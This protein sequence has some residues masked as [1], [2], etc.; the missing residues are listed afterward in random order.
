MMPMDSQLLD[1][2]ASM[3][4]PSLAPT[5]PQGTPLPHPLA[6]ARAHPIMFVTAVWLAAYV[7]IALMA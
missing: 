7:A 5:A 2:A 3:A 1:Q 4:R 6:V